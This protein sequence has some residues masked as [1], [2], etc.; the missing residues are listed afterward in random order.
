MCFTE[1]LTSYKTLKLMLLMNKKTEI[2]K[3]ENLPVSQ[4]VRVEP[5]FKAKSEVS[6]N[7]SS[8]SLWSIASCKIRKYRPFLKLFMKVL[9]EII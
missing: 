4:L 9:E 7:L 1:N 8:K 2:H 6:I 5:G 3:Y